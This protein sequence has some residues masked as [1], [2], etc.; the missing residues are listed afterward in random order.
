MCIAVIGAS[1]FVGR[2]LSVALAGA[3]YDVVALARHPPDIPGVRAQSVDV[4]DESSLR[5]AL[6]GCESAYYLVHSLSAGDFRDRDRELAEGCGRA[7]AAAGVGRIV[8]LG[9]L[10]DD[11]QSE[12]LV[13]RQEVGTALARGGVDI[14]ELRAAVVLGAGSVSF[15]LLRY[16]TERLPFMVC[17][18]WVRTAIQ[19]IALADVIRYLIGAIDVE[20][21]VYEI[22]GADTTTYREM[23]AA[24][25]SA[26]GLRR[27][28]IADVPY[29]TPRLSSYWLDLVTPVDR[30]VSHALVESLVTEVIVHDRARTDEAFGIEPLGL[31]DALALTLDDQARALDTDLLSREDGLRDG[32]YTVR[33]DV[34]VPT[35]TAARLDADLG[36][37]GGRYSWYGLSLAWRARSVL[38]RLVGERWNLERAH[39]IAAGENVDWWLITRRGP[40]ILVLRSIDWFP[41]EGWLGYRVTEH[42]LTQ[43]GALRPKGIPGFLYWKMLQ[44]IHR[45]VFRA[46]ARHRLK[47]AH[48]FAD[49][50]AIDV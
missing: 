49:P 27:R 19:P 50:H 4:A 32:I 22:G 18:R 15:E 26:R 1:G 3:G 29:L 5:A 17:P 6:D 41:G 20:P 34:A 16:L 23:I 35:D 30:R 38:G 46:L 44:P 42:E 13:S 28:R 43:V 39:P 40:G 36:R 47:R 33:V 37:I 8:Y 21:G 24:Y 7:A 14:V 11:P 2:A 48:D 25:A 9:G 31:V 10:G 12:H 45:R